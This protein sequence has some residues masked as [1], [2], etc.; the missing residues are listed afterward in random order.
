MRKEFSKIITKLARK[1]KSIYL[2]SGD[3]GIMLFD[4]FKEL[5]PSRFLNV[6]IREQSMIGIAA[7]M[8][9]QGLK[10]YVYTITPF[11]IERPFEQIKLDVDQQRVD[12]KLIGYADYLRMGPTHE[13]KNIRE[14]MGLFKNIKSYFPDNLEELHECLINSHKDQYPAFINLKRYVPLTF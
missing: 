8:A 5:F 14:I 12:V 4:E 2:L 11:L 10:P 1:D 3:N 13:T 7:G 6:G 9:L